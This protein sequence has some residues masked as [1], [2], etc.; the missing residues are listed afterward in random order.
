MASPRNTDLALAAQ[1]SLELQW[2]PYRTQQK[3]V[4][5]A[6]EHET[7]GETHIRVRAIA[8]Q[9]THLKYASLRGLAMHFPE[10]PGNTDL[11]L[12]ALAF[13]QEKQQ[14]KEG[15]S[16]FARGAFRAYWVDN[17]DLNDPSLV[18][19]LLQASGYTA[20]DFDA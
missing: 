16:A 10:Q 11:A 20:E 17:S 14:T 9:Q 1:F 15:P 12:A 19:Q 5:M 3:P 13:A 7:K 18:Q 2:H 4:P 8:R 6:G